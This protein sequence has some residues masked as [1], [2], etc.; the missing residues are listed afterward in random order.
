MDRF[1][2]IP[3]GCSLVAHGLLHELGHPHHPVLLQPGSDG[4][5]DAAFAALSPGRTVPVL[6][7][8]SGRFTQSTQILLH[9]AQ[10]YPAARL[11]PEDADA[12]RE[13]LDLLGFVTADVHPSFRPLLRP[14]RFVQQPDAQREL[15]E[16]ATER[17]SGQLQVLE[18]RLAQRDYLA[19]DQLGL[20]GP[21]VLVF[22]LW[23]KH[24]GLDYPEKLGDLAQR[25][26]AR[27]GYQRAIAIEQAARQA[28]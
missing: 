28:A 27:P 5:G 23:S 24:V 7:G 22:S 19:G 18:Q 25:V 21:Y 12:R 16:R 2:F 14:D 11:L 3:F 26:A 20:A 6:D 1:Y 13:A 10:L 4:L 8:D 9:L 15:R 17:L